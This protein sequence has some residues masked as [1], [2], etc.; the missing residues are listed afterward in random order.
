MQ[1]VIDGGSDGARPGHL[2]TQIRRAARH[3]KGGRRALP[4]S[5]WLLY[6]Y[7]QEVD[8]G[9][10]PLEYGLLGIEKGEIPIYL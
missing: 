7:A 6:H 10:N 2:P 9:Q 5:R 8:M 1:E 4:Y 3:G